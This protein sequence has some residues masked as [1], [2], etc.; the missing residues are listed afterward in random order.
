MHSFLKHQAPKSPTRVHEDPE[1]EVSARYHE[2]RRATLETE[3]LFARSATFVGAIFTLIT[4]FNP[5]DWAPHSVTAAIA[6]GTSLIGVVNLWELVFKLSERTLAHI[7][8]YK[9]FMGLQEKI[10][11]AGDNWR[12]MLPGWQA[13]AAAIR[14]DEQP[15]MWVV[16]A[17][18]WNQSIDRLRLEKT[19]YYRPVK[20]WQHLLR[21]I[22]KFSPQSFP[23]AP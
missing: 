6:L 4:A 5:L 23:A 16:Y 13:D 7:E 10:A 15:T 9:R 17:E 19:G 22:L 11:R 14:V 8:L 21:N 18:C 3:L 20:W 12:S 1:I 2:W